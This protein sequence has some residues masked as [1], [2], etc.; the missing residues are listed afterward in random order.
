MKF[1]TL[2]IKEGLF[3]KVYNFSDKCL[4]YSDENSRGKT[5]L[6]RMLLFALGY[7]IPPTKKISF[8]KYEFEL[9][10]FTNKKIVLTRRNSKINVVYDGFNDDFILP[11]QEVELHSMIFE[12][13]NFDVV[14]NL[15]GCFYLDQEK[16]WTL[17]NKGTVIGRIPFNIK[18]LVRGISNI[19]CKNELIELSNIQSQIQKYTTMLEVAKYQNSLRAVNTSYDKTLTVMEN[20]EASINDLKYKQ[21]DTNQ[22]IEMYNEIIKNNRNFM[23]YIINSQLIVVIDGKDYKL[24]KDNI[25]NYNDVSEFAKQKRKL[26]QIE[27]KKIKIELTRLYGELD[28]HHSLVS[29][30]TILD[31]F[32]S[33]VSKITIN[34][35]AVLNTLDYLKRRK[36]EL[37]SIVEQKTKYSGNAVQTIYNYVKQ[38]AAELNFSDY[39]EDEN[40]FIFTSDLKGLSGAVLHK[41]VFIFK[42]AYIK[43]IEDTYGLLLPIIL[44]SPKGKEVDSNNVKSMMKV[45]KNHFV[46]HQII[47]ASIEDDYDID[48]TK[49]YIILDKNGVLGSLESVT[50]K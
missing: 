42:M 6:L 47:I 24:T 36:R 8:S 19:D 13:G 10:I 30:E 33:K 40:I 21:T 7:N 49:P 27:L 15:L 43:L 29:G 37:E 34:E 4:I 1:V 45:L 22:K 28:K 14:E 3:E 17:L 35:N 48:L 46:S 18:S 41:L 25:K 38:F 39:F 2:K 23:E 44:D 12:I 31:Q 50:I 16:G 11:Q 26:L 5:T 20:L 9:E 32:N